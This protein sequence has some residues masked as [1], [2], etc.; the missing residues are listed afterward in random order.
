MVNIVKSVKS[1]SSAWRVNSAESG[2]QNYHPMVNSAESAKSLE[3]RLIDLGI[4]IALDKATGS[5]LLIFTECD[6][7]AVRHMATLHQS[8]EV[9]LTP[10]QRRKLTDDLE[11]YQDLLSRDGK[12]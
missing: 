10:S 1:P 12:Q 7:E 4:S 6:A 9:A 2:N 11:Y 8:F 3:A 5:A